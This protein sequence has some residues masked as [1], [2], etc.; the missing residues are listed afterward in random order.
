MKGRVL[1]LTHVVLPALGPWCKRWG[2]EAGTD[3]I[4]PLKRKGRTDCIRDQ[5]RDVS[6]TIG[7]ADLQRTA[8]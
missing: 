4:G 8:V 1:A 3:A 6:C 7:V 2:G 5:N